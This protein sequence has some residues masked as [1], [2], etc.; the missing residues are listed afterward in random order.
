MELPIRKPR[1]SF[2]EA[3][4]QVYWDATSIADFE[5]CPRYYQYHILEGWRG[6]QA[7]EHQ[8]FGG[9]FAT[10]LEHYY[11]YVAQGMEW[12]EALEAVVLEAL[13]ATW[14][15]GTPW[16]SLDANKTRETLIRSIVWYVDQFHA[17]AVTVKT[18]ANG[19]PAVEHSFQLPVDN[20]ITFVGHLDRVVEY[21]DNPYVMDQK[22]TKQTITPRWFD[23][24]KPNT[25][26]SMYTFA[27]KMIFNLPV[28]G[29]IIDGAQVAVGFTRFERGI[30]MRTEEEL[31]EWYW[32]TQYWIAQA[33][34]LT[35]DFYEYGRPLPM[36]PSSCDK[37]GGCAYR[38]VCQRTP[39]LREN[40]LRADFND[41]NPWDPVVPR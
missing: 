11:K 4:V 10:A 7:N 14:D 22:T 13:I 21:A 31:D 36:N 2:N 15:E 6:N 8:R 26:M 23:Q 33:Q 3:G 12:E 27:G 25:Q 24:F 1:K 41:S 35:F 19:A 9:H 40:F 29:V 17:E 16:Q 28:K 30:T 20:D 32:N 5:R 37:Y 18:L 34:Q 38:P 39:G